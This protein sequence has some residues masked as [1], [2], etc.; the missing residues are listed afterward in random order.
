MVKIVIDCYGGDSGQ[1]VTVPGGLDAIKKYNDLSIVF[2]G[3][4]DEIER[5]MESIPLTEDEKARVSIADAPNVVDMNEAP[6]VAI[7]RTDTSLAA[8]IS[9]VKQDDADGMIS[10][11]STGA[12]L[13]GA[14]LKIGRIRGVMRPACCP[15]L[16]TMNKGLVGVCDSGANAECKP[17]YLRQFAVMGSRYMECC[18]G[19]KNPRVALLN[20]GTEE[21]KG[22]ELHKEAY[23]LLKNT[24]GINFVGNMES[25]DL[26]SGKYDLVVCDGFSGNVLLK[27][28]EGA[29]LEMLKMLKREMT[30]SLKNKIGALFL[31]KSIMA[32][33]EFMDYRNYGGAVLLGTK[34]LVVKCHGNGDR[35][36]VFKCAE[37]IYLMTKSGVNERI[38]SDLTRFE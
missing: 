33:K 9:A 16:P 14:V 36:S 27:A 20:I 17:E 10:L 21:E 7:R 37:Q 6:T 31:K 13:T 19:V 8:A 32:Q 1:R 26:L 22:D 15:V 12:V 2:T 34:K 35:K 29:C 28:T 30:S 38:A 18:Y 11:G 23:V 24:D 4:K 25:R 3:K 5:E